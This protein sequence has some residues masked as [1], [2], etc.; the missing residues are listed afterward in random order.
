MDKSKITYVDTSAY[1][2]LAKL[3]ENV[4]KIGAACET[5]TQ[6]GDMRK[7]IGTP[8]KEQLL[9]EM[10][11]SITFGN[12]FKPAY[13]FDASKEGLFTINPSA[14]E[15]LDWVVANNMKMRGHVLVW[16]GQINIAIFAKEFKPVSE[17]KPVYKEYAKLD[18]ECLVDKEELLRRLRTYIYSVLEYTYSAGYARHIYAWDVVNEATDDDQPDGLRRSYWYQ[19]IGPEFLYYSFLYAREAVTKFSKK[20]AKQYGLDPKTDN[21]SEI[22]PKLFYND[23]N[24]WYEGRSNTIV[25]FLTEKKWNEDCSM[26]KSEVL[27]GNG[28]GTI[29]GD[30][31]LDGIGMQGHVNDMQDMEQYMRA[32]HKYDAAVDEVQITELDVGCSTTTK[33]AEYYQAK[34]YYEFYAR[35]KKEV[36]NGV[37]LTSVTV[38]GLTDD[39]SWRTEGRPL[40]F[41]GDLSRKPAYESLVRAA[42]G[43]PFILEPEYIPVDLSD[44]HMDFEP[45]MV[46]GSEKTVSLEDLGISVRNGGKLEICQGD[47]HSG[48]HALV[49]SDRYAPWMTMQFVVERFEGQEIEVQAW[50]KCKDDTVSLVADVNDVWPKLATV[51]TKDGAWTKISATYKVPLDKKGIR[52]FVESSGTNDI[53]L[54]DLD[55]HLIGLK[56]DFENE[57]SYNASPRGVG[58]QPHLS[59]TAEKQHSGKNSLLVTRTEQ[60][61]NM[62]FDVSAYTGRKVAISAYVFTTDTKIMMGLDGSTP[63]KL[64]E[65]ESTEDFTKVEAVCEIPEDRKV[66]NIYIETNGAADFYVDDITV[67]YVK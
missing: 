19:I 13:S 64:A 20:Y 1:E 57:S 50:V 36:E 39:A 6:F 54:D 24:E 7:E 4:F 38:W 61:A 37:H 60:D 14:K 48:T 33:N 66:A 2:S 59:I 34:F 47:S 49:S 44:I 55:I 42:K 21:L 41:R 9:K 67:R 52:L 46:D 65:A 29:Y 3:Y 35:L 43:E 11:N 8:E 63:Q 23:Y 12:E 22:I 15:M 18:E 27:T 32:L 40:L 26:V 51:E 56:E 5:K 10:F 28:D 58:H 62:R 25:N 53:Y 45:V 16:H 17:G 30:G 31:L